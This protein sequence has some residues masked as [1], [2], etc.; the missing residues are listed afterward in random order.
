MSKSLLLVIALVLL[1]SVLSA[2]NVVNGDPIV[3]GDYLVAGVKSLGI[4]TVN[5]V[6][7]N[8][9]MPIGTGGANTFAGNSYVVGSDDLSIGIGS[10][11]DAN[12]MQIYHNTV[13]HH[14]FTF[15]VIP[16]GGFTGKH[17][18]I[19]PPPPPPGKNKD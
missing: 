12:R 11:S 1:T 2:Q 3:S 16:P 9:I 13:L 6:L 19:M 14:D 10:I 5:I 8:G 15:D 17:I 18:S 7:F 4:G